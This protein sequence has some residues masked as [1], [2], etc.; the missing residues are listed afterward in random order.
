MTYRDRTF[1]S[2]NGC[3]KFDTCPRALTEAV[4]L[5]AEN[6][7]Y[8]VSQFAEPKELDCYSVPVHV[9]CLCLCFCF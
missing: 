6:L 7:G 4:K 9:F 5:Q 8:L 3:I 1:C 2:G